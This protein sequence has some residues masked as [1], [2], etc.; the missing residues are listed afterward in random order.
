MVC[1]ALE[2]DTLCLGPMNAE[3]D[4]R[5]AEYLGARH[6]QATSSCTTAL[7]LAAQVLGE[8]RGRGDNDASDVLGDDVAPAIAKMQDSFR[9]H[10]P[11]QSEHGPGNGGTA[12]QRKDEIHLGGSLR[13][14][15]RGHGPDP[16][17]GE[18]VRFN[19]RG[20]LLALPRS[21]VQGPEG[22]DAGRYRIS[23]IFIRAFTIRRSSGRTRMTLSGGWS[24]STAFRSSCAIFR[25]TCCRNSGRWGIPMENAFKTLQ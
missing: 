2:Q 7:Y 22:R 5:F 19:R 24:G 23:T 11:G 9:G 12:D 4:R 20:G 8:S 1:K 13:R 17:A 6:S 10:R 25:S 14:A 21:D 3:F 18:K 16:G 15:G